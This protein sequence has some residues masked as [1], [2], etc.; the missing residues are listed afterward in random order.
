VIP[1]DVSL[2]VEPAGLL[3]LM[4]GIFHA[5]GTNPGDRATSLRAIPDRAIMALV[6]SGRGLDRG[7]R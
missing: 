4:A 3:A 7:P 2:G 6:S 5:S 1:D